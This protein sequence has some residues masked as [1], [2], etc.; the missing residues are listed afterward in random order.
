[1]KGAFMKKAKST[2][3][4]LRTE[5]KRS[6]FGKLERGKY[7]ERVKA[8]SNV[9]VLDAEVAAVFPNSAAVNKALHSLVDVAQKASGVTRRSTGRGKQRRTG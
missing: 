4:E 2:P 3:D 7:Y 1:M 6:D 5:Y 8:S 9:V